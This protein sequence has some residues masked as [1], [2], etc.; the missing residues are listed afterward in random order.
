MTVVNGKR[1]DNAL[2]VGRYKEIIGSHTT[3]TDVLTGKIIDL[4]HDLPLTQREVLVLE[5]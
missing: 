5:F 3:A 2:E 1:T 4:T